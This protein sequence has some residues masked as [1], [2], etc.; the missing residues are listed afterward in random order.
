MT[1]LVKSM[2]LW[3]LLRSGWCSPSLTAPQSCSW[4][5]STLD[6]L[7]ERWASG[8]SPTAGEAGRSLTHAHC[9]WNI[10]AGPRQAPLALSCANLGEEWCG[11]SQGVLLTFFSLPNFGCFL[12]QQHAVTSWLASWTSTKALLSMGDCLN[13][14]SPAF[15]GHGQESLKPVHEL[16]QDPQLGPR[17]VC[18]LRNSWA[19]GLLPV[20]SACAAGSRSFQRGTFAVI[21]Y[22]IVFYWGKEQRTA[23]SIVLLMLRTSLN[24]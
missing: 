20:S 8:S 4:W 16:L 13:Q 7:K 5:L 21:G 9:L 11:Y 24:F 14:C 10:S 17:A 19:A 12:L 1:H 15:L 22:Q 2:F 23:Y 18:L 3:Y 6:W